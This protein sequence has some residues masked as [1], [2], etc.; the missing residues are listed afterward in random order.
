MSEFIGQENAF[1]QGY[2]AGIAAC[3]KHIS[4][5]LND[6]NGDIVVSYDD[7]LS[8]KSD[9]ICELESLLPKDSK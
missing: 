2:R 5:F 1:M 8:L 9:L 6:W 3:Q 7:A 4:T